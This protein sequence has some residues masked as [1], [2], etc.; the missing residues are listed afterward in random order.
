MKLGSNNKLDIDNLKRRYEPSE[1]NDDGNSKNKLLKRNTIASDGIPGL[2]YIENDIDMVEIR[3]KFS[4]N[5][6]DIN[7]SKNTLKLSKPNFNNQFDNEL[8]NMNMSQILKRVDDD[9]NFRNYI[10]TQ[11]N[12]NQIFDIKDKS[13]YVIPIVEDS[14]L[15]DLMIKKRILEIP[16]S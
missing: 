2:D 6:F 11:P 16:R 7:D 5:K 12:N 13:V 8:N 9:E 15:A 3:S 10:D 4:K 14:M 1:N